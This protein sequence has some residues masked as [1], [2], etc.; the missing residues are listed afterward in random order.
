M[1]TKNKDGVFNWNSNKLQ[2]SDNIDNDPKKIFSITKRAIN[3]I[4]KNKENDTPFYLQISHYAIHSDIIARKKTYDKFKNK[5]PGI[6]HNN[7]GLA[8]MTY[9]LDESV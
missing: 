9:D 7:L 5:N 2:W 4:E 8:A 1:G 3:F 6:I